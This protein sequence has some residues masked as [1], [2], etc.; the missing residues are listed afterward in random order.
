MMLG[1]GHQEV[2]NLPRVPSAG[3]A[4]GPNASSLRAPCWAPETTEKESEETLWY[5]GT[6]PVFCQDLLPLTGSLVFFCFIPN[7][8]IPRIES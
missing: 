1:W 4:K 8:P 2:P 3:L 5:G 7:F 6:Q